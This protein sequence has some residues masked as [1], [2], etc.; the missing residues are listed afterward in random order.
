MHVCFRLIVKSNVT[1]LQSEDGKPPKEF[2][3][4]LLLFNNLILV[5]ERHDIANPAQPKRKIWKYTVMHCTALD[6]LQA[7]RLVAAFSVSFCLLHI[8]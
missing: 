6:P 3:C 2:K 4:E 7:T 8:I 1:R 5:L